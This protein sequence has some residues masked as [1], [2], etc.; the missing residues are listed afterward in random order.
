MLV[1]SPP[2]R[3]TKMV[4]NRRL[5]ALLCLLSRQTQR[6]NTCA[7]RGNAATTWREAPNA[8]RCTKALIY[9]RPGYEAF[10]HAKV[11]QES[12]TT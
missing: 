12:G 6:P 9:R 3:S 10:R 5:Q 7:T 8:R 1:V 2:L 4:R 11:E